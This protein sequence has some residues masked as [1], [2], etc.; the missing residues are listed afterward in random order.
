MAQGDSL[1]RISPAHG[2][3]VGIHCARG[4]ADGVFGGNTLDEC[5]WYGQNSEGRVHAVRTK[6]A[7]A[8]GVYDMSGNVWEWVWDGYTGSPGS[9]AIQ[10]PWGLQAARTG[11]ARGGSWALGAQDARAWPTASSTTRPPQ[12]LPGVSF[13]EVLPHSPLPAPSLLFSRLTLMPQPSRSLVA[14]LSP[15]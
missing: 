12:R 11:S 1:S 13:V 14:T 7:N 9:C 8:W 3:R 4:Q 2:R 10:I 5:G 15:R 6:R